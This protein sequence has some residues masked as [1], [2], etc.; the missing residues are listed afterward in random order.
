LNNVKN[1]IFAV[2]LGAGKPFS[3]EQHTALR[4][5]GCN[6]R[7]LDWTLDALSAFSPEYLFVTGYQA[8]NIRASYPDV[9]FRHNDNWENTHAGWSLLIGLPEIDRECIVS[10]SDVLYRAPTVKRLMEAEG[11]IVIAVDTQWRTRF[12][13]R[14]KSD[15]VRCEKA[16]LS[17]DTVTQISAD[18]SGANASAEVIGL[19]RL[20]PQ[21][22]AAL[23]EL[24]ESPMADKASLSQTRLSDLIEWLRIRGMR[25][26]AIDVSGEW[27][28]MNE[29]ADLARFILGTK[30]QT[31]SR[32]RGMVSHSRISDQVSFT[33]HSW[34]RNPVDWIKAIQSQFASEKVV[35]RSSALSEDGFSNSNAGAYTTLLDIDAS[36]TAS[37]SEAIEHVIASFSDGNPKNE[38]LVQPMLTAVV[39]SGVAFTRTLTKAAP[40]YVV[41]YDD[42][43]G[44]TESITSGK[45][46]EHKTLLIRRDADEESSAIPPCLVA[47]LP[48]LRE[49]ES[50]LA[51]EQL[52]IEFAVTEG[53]QLQ[54]LQV[55]PIAVDGSKYE[56]DDASVYAALKHA[57]V[58]FAERQVC[59]PWVH[60]RRTLFGIMPDWNPAEIIG[61]KPG[62]L[63]VSLYR[64]LITDDVWATQ[65]A[66]Y[67]YRDVRP[68]PLLLNF[69][70]HPY[71][72]VRASFNSFL[73]ADLPDALTERI[74]NFCLRWLEEHP[75]LHDKVEF[76]VIPTC[77]SLDFNLWVERL[78]KFS[79]LTKE[80]LELWHDELKKITRRALTRNYND[81]ANISLLEHRYA[82]F[83]SSE[84]PPLTKAFALLDDAKRYGTLSFAHL[85]RSAFIAI[86]LLR[87]AVATGVISQ[88]EMDGFL[89]TIRT[90]S[91]E[92]TH[93]AQMCA[94]GN[95]AWEVF[96]ERYG[97]LRPGT[98]DITSPSY[99]QNPEYYLRPLVIEALSAKNESESAFSDASWIAARSRF[100]GKLNAVG[101]S[102]T[103]DSIEAFLRE[104]IEGREHAKFVF[105]RN[106]SAAL[107]AICKWGN[108]I[109]IDADILSEVRIDQLSAIHSGQVSVTD[110]RTLLVEHAERVREQRALVNAIELPPLLCRPEDFVVFQYPATQANFIGDAAILSECIE[111]GTEN[112]NTDVSGK[113][114]LIV[115]A[116]PGYDWLFG[117][118]IAGL[119]TMYGGANSHMAIRAAEFGLPAA[120]GVGQ[121]LYSSLATAK[122]IELNPINRLIR[123]LH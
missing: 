20:S 62:Q 70:G 91:H 23:R 84:M 51:Y 102:C 81:L 92:F 16:C 107:D 67:G 97:H 36:C 114:V 25:V 31:L 119:I 47:L 29:A 14:K 32:L 72:D 83:V 116:D 12:A 64:M 108:D 113:I 79:D 80:E 111:L 121:I 43:S 101:L 93:D 27:A 28:E 10:Y 68:H 106:V 76:E 4:N 112:G 103:E 50:L 44:S 85:A 94:R 117:R 88:P 48:A 38:L 55:R 53:N 89:K 11:D 65:R 21:A 13:G 60:G 118:Q 61:T 96:V 73:P 74:V 24:F 82:N 78:S 41:N 7:V 54:I 100:V 37:L 1:A 63:A 66:E 122:K 39:A 30:A 33:V 45:S 86:T 34:Q 3:G 8:Q 77:L 18:L 69:A 15:L 35:V 109:G 40:Y 26:S 95:L 22:I 59:P 87:S 42:I 99:R 6:A 115:Q 71:V 104:S 5:L 9:N 120:I 56:V 19:A 57:E 110:I 123:V 90:V 46:Q 2:V 75:E 58:L 49:I 17:G 98:Y 52:D 105:T